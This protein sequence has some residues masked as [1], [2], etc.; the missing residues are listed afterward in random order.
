MSWWRSTPPPDPVPP[1]PT[2][3]SVDEF[4]SFKRELHE[5]LDFIRQAVVPQQ[6]PL[7][8]QED[9]LAAPVIDD[10]PD[11]DYQSALENLQSP[12][13]DGDRRSQ[14]RIIQKRE[15]AERERLKHEVL[16]TVHREISSR[17]AIIHTVNGQNIQTGLQSLPY[18]SLLKKEIDD[19][20]ARVPLA[21]R[22]M[23]MATVIHNQIES[24]NRTRVI[25]YEIARRQQ[26]QED[27]QRT[28]TDIPGRRGAPGSK[29]DAITFE[30]YFGTEVSA[31]DATARGIPL[32]DARSRTRRDAN[33][34]AQSRG[35][36]NANDYAA[37]SQAMM[38]ITR[39]PNCFMEAYNGKPCM[40][41]S[42]H[43]A[44]ERVT[45]PLK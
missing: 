28:I 19:Q 7:E 31:P 42:A 27:Q 5:G 24:Q 26:A 15:K 23:A 14:V 12:D 8:V 20:L 17:D 33:D 3:V 4:N 16:S 18:Y 44:S 29:P 13:F 34:F 45:L 41:G 37:F 32:W 36:E 39:C 40:C 30:S 1:V 22:T 9:T 25:D 10:V 35:F 21:Q 38:Q 2:T 11:D 6:A 43:P